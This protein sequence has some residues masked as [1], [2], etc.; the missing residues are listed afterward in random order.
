[1]SLH[2]LN[3]HNEIESLFVVRLP[4]FC[5]DANAFNAFK[6]VKKWHKT[7]FAVGQIKHI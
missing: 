7:Y 3:F 5:Q 6:S 2:L 1:M 4:L